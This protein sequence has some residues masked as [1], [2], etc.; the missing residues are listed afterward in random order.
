[1]IVKVCGMRDPKNIREV[2]ELGV[3]WMGFILW[4]K[5]PRFVPTVPRYLPQ[6]TKRVGVFVDM[7]K[8]GL[9]IFIAAYRLD[10]VQF[11]GKESP[12]FIR[13]VR[14]LVPGLKTIKA[15]SISTREDLL[16]TEAYE[17]VCDYF[18]FDTKCDS[19]GGSGEQF[20]WSLLEAYQ[21]KTPF[22]L[23][24]G[25]GPDSIPALKELHHPLWAGIDL[26][27]RFEIDK[28]YKDVELLKEFL[29]QLSS[30]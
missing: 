4:P 8:D 17:G 22:L 24:G 23:S 28:A 13:D 14:D 9:L 2:E 25:I 12:E 15:F 20:D 19:V 1:M 29:S 11:H 10:L 3:D 5:S 18:L 27:S 6:K 16:A 26:N 7:N 21:G 30:I